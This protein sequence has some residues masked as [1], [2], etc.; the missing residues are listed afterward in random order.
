MNDPSPINPSSTRVSMSICGAVDVERARRGARDLTHR[1]G[2]DRF[3]AE[4]VVLAVSEL[5]TNLA[6]YATSG[7]IELCAISGRQLLGIRVESRDDG[8]GIADVAAAARGG[9][10]STSGGL[11]AGLAGVRRLMDD[12]ELT[13]SPT[14]TTV[15]CRKWRKT[16]A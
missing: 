7:E 4:E 13:S 10:S 5:A 6:R 14:G 15:V 1:L 12:F 9:G 3:A 16:A 8:P 2:F 11:G